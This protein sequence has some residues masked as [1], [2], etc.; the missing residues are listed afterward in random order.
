MM[1]AAEAEQ[2]EAAARLRD[3]LST[4]TS[5]RKNSAPPPPDRMTTRRLRLPLRGRLA[6]R[7][8]L[9]RPRRQDRRPPRIFL[10]DLPELLEA[11]APEQTD[12]LQIPGAPGLAFETWES[13]ETPMEG[14]QP[15][16]RA[17]RSA[18]RP[19]QAALHRPALRSA[20]HPRPAEFDDREALARLLTERTGHRIEIAV[21][22]RGEKR[23]L[24]DLAGQNAKQSYIQRFRVSNPRAR[25]FRRLW[26]SF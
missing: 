15:P 10:E 7:E 17:A 2:F 8:S 23:S 18:Q 24:V 3:Q 4:S 12:S 13:S 21:P 6:G 19:A 11:A 5:S 14:S 26:P 20:L 1:D 9:P 22:L 25:P 16:S